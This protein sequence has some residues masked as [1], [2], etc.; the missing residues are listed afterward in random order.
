M[1]IKSQELQGTNEK[2]GLNPNFTSL[3]Q[4]RL[5]VSKLTA[6]MS[7]SKTFTD[8]HM[9]S[10]SMFWISQACPTKQNCSTKAELWHM[11]SAWLFSS[12]TAQKKQSQYRINP[13][14]KVWEACVC[15]S[16]TVQMYL[17]LHRGS[18]VRDQR[19]PVCTHWWGAR[20]IL[21]SCLLFAKPQV[22]LTDLYCY[23]VHEVSEKT[24]F[25]SDVEVGS[26]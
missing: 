15:L 13:S 26:L 10:H 8:G 14:Q 22:S 24:R 19:P 3:I 4:G 25:A 12:R 18:V 16:N 1:R 5:G 17:H 6:V 20:H 7:R 21:A 11:L 23:F 2:L 9:L